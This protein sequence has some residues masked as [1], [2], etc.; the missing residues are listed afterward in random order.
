MAVT[1]QEDILN[2]GSTNPS[3]VTNTL[4]AESKNDPVRGKTPA[5]PVTDLAKP[6]ESNNQVEHPDSSSHLT[7]E[8]T[9]TGTILDRLG[10]GLKRSRTQDT[11]TK[12]VELGEQTSTKPLS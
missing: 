2:Q 7:E 11:S 4:S 9:T 10:L 3:K 12:D 8:V 6:D 5:N 1:E